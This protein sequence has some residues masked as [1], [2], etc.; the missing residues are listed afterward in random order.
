[1]NKLLYRNKKWLKKKYI[2]ENLSSQEIADLLGLKSG[3]TIIKWLKKFDI[4]RRQIYKERHKELLKKIS[5][6]WL[7]QKYWKEHLSLTKIARLLGYKTHH[8][9]VQRLFQYY[10]IPRR[11]ARPYSGKY[12]WNWKGRITCKK[13]GYIYIRKGNK[14]IAEHTLVL[15]NKIG[16]K[17]VNG[18]VAHHKDGNPSNNK[19]TNLLL[20]SSNSS[21]QIYEANLGLF[22]KQLLWGKIK[23]SNRK[24]LL[25]LFNNF[26]KEHK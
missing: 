15:E 16:R 11:P 5:K 4:P 23:T 13:N 1:M 8:Y 25:E 7:I 21:H 24:F 18:E 14:Y 9:T 20:L 19:P 17:L 3:S 10:D 2:N 6:E 26:I 12:A 22:A